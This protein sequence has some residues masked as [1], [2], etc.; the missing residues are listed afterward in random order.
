MTRRGGGRMRPR[1]PSSLVRLAQRPERRPDLLGEQARLFPRGEVAALVDL[2]EVNQVVIQTPVHEVRYG[3]QLRRAATTSSYTV[4]GCPSGS[5]AYRRR[6]SLTRIVHSDGSS[7]DATSEAVKK[8]LGSRG[9]A[10]GVFRT[11][12][13]GHSHRHPAAM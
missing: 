12:G 13:P 11:A 1:L 4:T 2:V 6:A 9:P 10:A 5:R 3:G 8:S 7:A